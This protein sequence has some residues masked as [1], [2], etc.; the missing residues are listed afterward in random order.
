M[1]VASRMSAISR[2][3]FTARIASSSGSRSVSVAPGA[4]ACSFSRNAASR[5]GRPS[6]GSSR[7]LRASLVGSPDDWLP[8]TSS[9]KGV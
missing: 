9:R 2:G 1:R 3:L 4:A 7:L 6:H 5:E 8:S